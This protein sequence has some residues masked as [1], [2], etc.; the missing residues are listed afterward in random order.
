M[1]YRCKKCRL[2]GNVGVCDDKV[3]V[4]FNL[5]ST[6]TQNKPFNDLPEKDQKDII[7]GAMKRSKKLQDELVST[8]TQNDWEKRFHE[9]FNFKK[10]QSISWDANL[11][12]DAKLD[13]VLCFIRKE[14]ADAREEVIR[15]VET[16]RDLL[17]ATMK[18]SERK[19]GY[20]LSG[21]VR[22]SMAILATLR[23]EQV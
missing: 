1:K 17:E 20:Y 9:R 4:G 6:T 2:E 5:G 3:C 10:G 22:L 23:K 16:Q 8:T 15:E 13:D 21:L 18:D 11:P 14:L 19:S 7:S 12:T